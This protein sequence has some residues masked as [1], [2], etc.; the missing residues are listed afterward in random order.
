MYSSKFRFDASFL[1]DHKCESV[2]HG[3]SELLFRFMTDTTC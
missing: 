3:L 2:L 1:I